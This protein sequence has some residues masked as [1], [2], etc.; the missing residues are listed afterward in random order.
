MPLRIKVTK[1]HKRK[2]P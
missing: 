2:L 1:L